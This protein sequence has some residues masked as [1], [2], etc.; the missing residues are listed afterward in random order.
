MNTQRGEKTRIRHVPVPRNLF[1][2]A[3]RLGNLALPDEHGGVFWWWGWL[4][5]IRVSSLLAALWARWCLWNE[6]W[7]YAGAS[8][9]F[10][11]SHL[12]LQVL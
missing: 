10:Y 11:C 7:H 6:V 4:R 1:D 5:R 2:E 8:P 9:L 3:L 12:L